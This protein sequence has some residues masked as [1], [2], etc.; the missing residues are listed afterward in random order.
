MTFI[1]TSVLLW[2]QQTK[3]LTRKIFLITVVRHWISTL[4]RSLLIPIVILVL[5][6]EIQN[7][8]ANSSKLGVGSPSPIQA[9]SDS[10]PNGARV[11]FVQPSSLGSDVSSVVKQLTDSLGSKAR[12]EFIEDEAQLTKHCVT[13]LNGKADCHAAVIFNDS[14]LS[15]AGNK[16]WNYT[17]RVSSASSTS[18]FNVNQKNS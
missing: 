8:S 10:L 18:H 2:L 15:P 16:H 3:A 4:I 7:F 1:F 5:V 11:L 12:A 13:N 14:P 9:L 6:L 17:I